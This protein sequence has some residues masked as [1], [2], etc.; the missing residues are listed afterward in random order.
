MVNWISSLLKADILW[1]ERKNDF[2]TSWFLLTLTIVKNSCC[3]W[4]RLTLTSH[5]LEQRQTACLSLPWIWGEVYID[6]DCRDKT[7]FS[8]NCFISLPEFTAFPIRRTTY[9][10]S[11]F[12]H[13][14]ESTNST[15]QIFKTSYIGTDS[16]PSS[17]ELDI[18]SGEMPPIN[19]ETAVFPPGGTRSTLHHPSSA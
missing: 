5:P 17:S 12:S 11:W 2:N 6:G 19:W 14:Q 9:L 13:N 8:W 4:P 18:P 1:K 3:S 15:I 10:N 7:W 16:E